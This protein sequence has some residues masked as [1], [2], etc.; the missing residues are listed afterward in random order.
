MTISMLGTVSFTYFAWSLKT[1]LRLVRSLY[2]LVCSLESKIDMSD[3]LHASFSLFVSI[4]Q[5]DSVI[6]FPGCLHTFS[7]Y[8]NC[9]HLHQHHKK[10]RFSNA[11]HLVTA[12]RQRKNTFQHY[13][14]FPWF[15]CDGFLAPRIKTSHG[16]KLENCNVTDSWEN[17]QN[18]VLILTIV[19]AVI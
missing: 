12:E 9:E 13:Q 15:S 17:D 2:F 10:N 5:Y 14:C 8:Q 11:A 19:W 16:L 1:T 18:S 4:F 6:I 3:F 7:E